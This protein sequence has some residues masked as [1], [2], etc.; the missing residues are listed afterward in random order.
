MKRLL[1]TFGG[2]YQEISS[3]N[4]SQLGILNE[5]IICIAIQR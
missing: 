3:L 1:T 5:S 4:I 2:D